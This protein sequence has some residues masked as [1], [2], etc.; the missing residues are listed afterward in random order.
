MMGKIHHQIASAF[1]KGI[2]GMPDYARVIVEAHRRVE[3]VLHKNLDIVL[4]P[5]SSLIADTWDYVV[6]V[7]AVKLIANRH[8]YFV[9]GS[10]HNF[11]TTSSKFNP[12]VEFDD[13]L[14]SNSNTLESY[15]VGNTCIESDILFEGKLPKL[16]VGDELTIKNVGSYSVVMKP[17]FIH[18]NV[19]VV[20]IEKNKKDK[21][22]KRNETMADIFKTFI[23]S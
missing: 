15:V 13:S 10:A 6:V 4:E 14:R 9:D 7:K 18:P 3:K 5:G 20:A 22:I 19:S 16:K 23:F 8:Y 17:P 12:A 1:P 11:K 21:I 2:H